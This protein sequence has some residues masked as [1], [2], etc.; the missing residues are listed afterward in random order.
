MKF[1]M[2]ALTTLLLVS[3]SS[4]PFSVKKSAQEFYKKDDARICPDISADVFTRKEA[5]YCLGW[6]YINET[7]KKLPHVDQIAFK[8]VTPGD[9]AIPYLWV[10]ISGGLMK[11][12]SPMEFGGVKPITKDEWK[13]SLKRTEEMIAEWEKNNPSLRHK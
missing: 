9:P 13:V 10:V 6:I 1:T 3:C 12:Q 5:A 11:P 8:D 2:I 4:Q 7:E